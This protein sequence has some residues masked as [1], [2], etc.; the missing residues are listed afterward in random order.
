M[1]FIVASERAGIT[2]GAGATT[3]ATGCLALG[4]GS[5][6]TAALVVPGLAVA[7]L[8][9]EGLT[10]SGFAGADFGDAT[11]FAFAGSAF[12]GSGFALGVFA[13]GTLGSRDGVRA[14]LTLTASSFCD[15]VFES[16]PTTF[17]EFLDLP[18]ERALRAA[19]R[20]GVVL[21]IDSRV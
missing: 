4:F 17:A 12:A 8:V 1:A 3:S 14:E 7:G 11:G 13:L 18:D 20:A 9:V 6:F 5:T 15:F 19:P 2:A 16:A 10:A 21:A